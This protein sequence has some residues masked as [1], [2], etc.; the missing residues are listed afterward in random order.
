MAQ[1]AES[2]PFG[3]VRDPRATQGQCQRWFGV[4]QEFIDSWACFE[5]QPGP[6]P[7]GRW[8]GLPMWQRPGAA[9]A[10]NRPE[11]TLLE[12]WRRLAREGLHATDDLVARGPGAEASADVAR[13][14]L[15]G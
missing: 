10:R 7:P 4:E 14:L 2:C 11:N 1:G 6:A 9:S 8:R 13:A 15:I 3:R 12:R 5:P